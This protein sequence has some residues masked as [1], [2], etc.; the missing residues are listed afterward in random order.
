[1]ARAMGEEHRQEFTTPPPVTI[2][3]LP[4]TRLKYAAARASSEWVA[5]RQ[6]VRGRWAIRGTPE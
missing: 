3:G 1:V 2:G 5:G 6:L 4:E